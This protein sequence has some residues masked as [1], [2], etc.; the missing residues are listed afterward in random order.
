MVCDIV[1]RRYHIVFIHREHKLELG[2]CFRS[3]VISLFKGTKTVSCADYYF[4]GLLREA[5]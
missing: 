2:L 4:R 5:D 3:L 1:I